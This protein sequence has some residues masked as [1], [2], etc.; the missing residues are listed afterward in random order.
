M[1]LSVLKMYKWPAFRNFPPLAKR[2]LHWFWPR[3]KSK[4][5]EGALAVHVAA[6]LR[7]YLTI[8]SFL[9]GTD[10]ETSDM[11]VGNFFFFKVEGFDSFNNL[12]SNST[13]AWLVV[14]LDYHLGGDPKSQNLRNAE[15]ENRRNWE[16]QN[17]RNVRM[18]KNCIVRHTPPSIKVHCLELKMPSSWTVQFCN[19]VA[20]LTLII[21]C[22][23]GSP[24]YALFQHPKNKE[25]YI[26][27]SLTYICKKGVFLNQ[28]WIATYCQTLL[29]HFR[30][31]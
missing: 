28:L 29:T 6:F 4:S 13:S 10:K 3:G 7:P 1:F 26:I 8:V 30:P 24:P 20:I 15:F 31:P 5:S 19:F 23:L 11:S 14:Q 12:R 18:E 2:I 16:T 22:Y 27:H 17:L 9:V 21:F 25:I